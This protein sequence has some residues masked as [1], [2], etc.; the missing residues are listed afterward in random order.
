VSLS[1][2]GGVATG[3]MATLRFMRSIR[4]RHESNI[5][6]YDDEMDDNVIIIDRQAV[7]GLTVY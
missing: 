1:K 2:L 6:E 4:L 5:N 3:L 7:V